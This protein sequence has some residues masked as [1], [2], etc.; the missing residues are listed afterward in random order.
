MLSFYTAYPIDCPRHLLD[1][2]RFRSTLFHPPSM[3]CG[4][5]TLHSE[6]VFQSTRLI[7]RILSVG[8]CTS[9]VMVFVHITMHPIISSSD[10]D[11]ASVT[12]IHCSAFFDRSH[13]SALLSFLDNYTPLHVGQFYMHYQAFNS[14]YWGVCP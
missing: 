3:N 9:I 5:Q 14:P 12:I 10:F 13:D 6:T 7:N 1:N 11:Q 4:L 8:L 2:V